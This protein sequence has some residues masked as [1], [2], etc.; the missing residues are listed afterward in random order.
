MENN[1]CNL[2]YILTTRN[3][4]PFLKVTLEKLLVEILPDEEIVV[5]DGNSMDGTKEYLKE[6]FDEGK[7]NQYI[8]EP[9]KNQAHGWNKAML[10]SKGILIKKII[11]D[12]VFCYSAIRECKNFMLQ[13][14]NIDAC[15][16]NSLTVS[17]GDIKNVEEHSRFN[18]FKEWKQGVTKSF[19]FS[20]VYL[21]LRRS[22]L[23]YTGLYDTKFRMLDWEYSLRI[24]YLKSNLAY[25]TGFMAM[26]VG[27]PGNVTSETSKEVLAREGEIGAYLYEYAGDGSDI[28]TWSKIKIAI[29]KFLLRYKS[30]DDKKVDTS[31]L[32]NLKEFY[33]GAYN[34]IESKNRNSICQFY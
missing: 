10:L 7:I 19:T 21:M 34:L 28:S 24:S 22:S 16:S 13:N 4:L 9:D 27:T 26:C 18:Y 12:D 25:Y 11:D 33:K 1:N 17:L 6:L 32:V 29:G 8:S 3:R 20:D 14:E 23:A 15:I 31:K 30:K 5:V 2:S